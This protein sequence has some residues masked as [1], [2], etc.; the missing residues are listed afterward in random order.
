MKN[1]SS[2]V[3]K[4]IATLR[5]EKKYTQ[6]ELAEKIGLAKTSITNYETGTREPSFEI[7]QNIANALE[8]D[9]QTFFKEKV[10]ASDFLI[11]FPISN[12]IPIISHA[13]AGKGIFGIEEILDYIELP[14]KLSTK[15]DFAT[16]VNGNSMEPKIFHGDIICIKRDVILE[17]GDIGL[18]FLNDNIYVKK[19]NFNPFT[20][21]FSL[22]SLNKNYDP[23]II[24]M[25]DEFHELGKVICKFDYNF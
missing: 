14:Q 23:I 19:F 9:I 24:T 15:C 20:N 3:A 12:K 18:F 2:L 6:K 16:Y 8:V 4:N 25:N 21:E 1:I 17:N 11:P 10:D 7:L 13:S 5:V 22:I